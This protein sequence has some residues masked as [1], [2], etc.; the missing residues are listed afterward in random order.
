MTCIR[1]VAL[2]LSLGVAPLQAQ[3]IAENAEG[4]VRV[5]GN[6][7]LV[8]STINDPSAVRVGAPA[9]QNGVGKWSFDVLI[10]GSR[11]EIVMFQGKQTTYGD[12]PGG[13]WWGG[14]KRPNFGVGDDRAMFNWIEVSYNEGVRFYLPV[15]APAFIG[16][17]GII[18]DHLATSAWRIY[19]QGDGNFVLYEIVEGRPCPRWAISWLEHNGTGFIPRSALVPPCN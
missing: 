14:I 4:R 5:A 6:E 15:Y 7:L 1:S 8:E 12:R 3:T 9:T 10:G 16:A 11:D 2:V 13:V 19:V 17:V 18:P